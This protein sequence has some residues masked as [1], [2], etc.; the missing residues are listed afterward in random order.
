MLHNHPNPNVNHNPNNQHPKMYPNPQLVI[1]YPLNFEPKLQCN[2]KLKYNSTQRLKEPGP[3]SEM[4][5]D[6]YLQ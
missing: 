6:P 3:A 5:P 2:T 4:P 1:G